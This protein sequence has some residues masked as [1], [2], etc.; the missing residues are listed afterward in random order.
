MKRVITRPT[1]LLKNMPPKNYLH[2]K[3]N[4]QFALKKHNFYF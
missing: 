3:P 1:V 4:P 2:N